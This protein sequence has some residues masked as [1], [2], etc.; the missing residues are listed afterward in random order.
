MRLPKDGSG[1]V[2]SWY[3]RNLSATV[4]PEPVEQQPA[5]YRPPRRRREADPKPFHA[6]PVRYGIRPELHAIEGDDGG[7]AA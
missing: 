7:A 1:R 5:S 6:H 4:P 2:K 3:E